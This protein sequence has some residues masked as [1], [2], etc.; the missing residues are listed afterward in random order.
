MSDALHP[1][2]WDGVELMKTSFPEPRYAVPGLI[3][4]GLTL[5]CSTPK[6][7]KSWWALGVCLDIARGGSAL[8][9]IDVERGE[10]LYLALEDTPRRLRSRLLKLLD[11]TAMPPGLNL[12]TE[13]SPELRLEPVRRH[14]STNPDTRL[15]VVDVL[16]KTRPIG[17]TGE[18]IYNADYR[19]A[20]E[21]K[22]LADEFGVAVVVVHHTRK[23]GSEDFL[24]TVS[25]TNGLA[26]AADAIIVMRRSRG[27]ADAEMHLTGRDVREAKF[28]MRFDEDL[29]A[30]NLLEGPAE[31]HALPET[32]RR[33]V[34]L[35]ADGQPRTPKQIA[36]ALDVTHE[37]VKKTCQRMLE[38]D[39]LDAAEGYY[40]LSPLSP[41][42][43]EEPGERDTGDRRDT[44][45]GGV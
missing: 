27:S 24:D 10:S 20:G 28:A 9:S 22:S 44:P 40:T 15:V 19:T 32:R 16:A 12:V 41:L 39:Q 1:K 6:F 4:E 25:G 37:N 13:W 21:W 29:G 43:P 35:L 5:L 42:S 45:E 34:T 33:I 30:W 17:I 14:L 7:G 23:A 2:V 36:E 18:S 26:G 31:V 11:G 8:G 38:A 3:P